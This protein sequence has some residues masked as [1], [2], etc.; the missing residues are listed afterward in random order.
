MR[1]VKYPALLTVIIA[2]F[3]LFIYEISRLDA[4]VGGGRSYRGSY[5]SR[6]SSS[7]GS[8][9][10][11]SSGGGGYRRSSGGGGGSID[12]FTLFIAIIVVLLFKG[13]E[14]FNPELI[15][16]VLDENYYDHSSLNTDS[17]LLQL[18]QEDDY[19]SQIVAKRKQYQTVKK[20]LKKI[21]RV[22]LNFSLP[23]FRDFVGLIF[24]RL[25]ILKVKDLEPLRPYFA[26]KCFSRLLAEPKNAEVTEIL[27]VIIGQLGLT[28]VRVTNSYTELTVDIEGNFTE[29][30][31][32]K[33]TGFY[34]NQLFLFRK[35][36]EIL[37]KKPEVMT[38]LGC[39]CCGNTSIDSF[40]GNCTA[41]GEPMKAGL[42]NWEITAIST[43]EFT[44]KDRYEIS[45]KA[46]FG[47]FFPTL[48]QVDLAANIRELSS[49]DPDFSPGEFTDFVHK[50]F[51]QLQQAWTE[52]NW[53]VFRTYETDA[54]YH[55][56]KYWM[57]TYAKKGITN[58]IEDISIIQVELAKV[59]SDVF[60]DSITVRI[61]A[62][63]VDVDV[64]STG[65]VI[66]GKEVPIKFSEYWTYIR[67]TNF[68]K[69]KNENSAA[70]PSC[71]APL[72]INQSGDCEYCDSRVCTGEFNWVLSTIAQ[73]E[74]YS[75]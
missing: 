22:D 11:S 65:K 53:Q 24:T 14:Y 29:V 20:G 60:F 19:F 39:P 31:A 26:E 70:C 52:K 15:A 27:E 48:K 36:N 46:E 2:L 63:M 35:S 54:L 28:D 64:D 66:A 59:E 74:A 1:L 40:R 18:E 38:A 56:H 32:G 5:R 23:V 57:D 67:S 41:C 58:K 34:I 3:F 51:I 7:S 10:R 75:G 61:R 16:K 9:Y 13:V 8:G 4:R 42:H 72:E 55:S 49:R 73:D 21:F 12:G 45:S 44:P 50:N 47:D 69:P 68:K 37:S 6:S 17:G 30:V 25:H 43:Q 33:E 71:G 62:A